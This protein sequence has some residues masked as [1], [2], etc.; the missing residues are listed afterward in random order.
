MGRASPV[1]WTPRGGLWSPACTRR[2][3]AMGWPSARAICFWSRSSRCAGVTL[4]AVATA[5]ELTVHGGTVTA[6]GTLDFRGTLAVDKQ[7]PVGLK[8]IRLQF[9]LESDATDEQLETLLKLT[10]GFCVVYQTLKKPP[11]LSVS[12]RRVTRD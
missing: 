12:H 1:E 4:R 10:E 8:E 9:D 3:V 7:V 5:L 2:P 11:A 6:H